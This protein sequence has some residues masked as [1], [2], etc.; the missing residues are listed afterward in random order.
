MN[1]EESSVLFKSNFLE[2]GSSTND[3]SNPGLEVSILS[4]DFSELL[5]LWI[6]NEVVEVGLEL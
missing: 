6:R 1:L 5:L 4:I 2:Q 3:I